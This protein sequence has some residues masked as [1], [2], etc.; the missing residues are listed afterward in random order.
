MPSKHLRHWALWLNP[1]YLSVSMYT[2]NVR[3]IHWPS[4]YTVTSLSEGKSHT[5][6]TTVWV[7]CSNI[8][9]RGQKIHLMKRFSLLFKNSSSYSLFLKEGCCTNVFPDCA[10]C[11]CETEQRMI[12]EEIITGEW[13]KLNSA[14]ESSCRMVTKW[15]KFL[16]LIPKR[17]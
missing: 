1:K 5:L 14:Q 3:H 2:S 17:R 13:G 7:Q 16:D 15:Q 8:F 9:N 11:L 12:L 10:T 4:N 6:K